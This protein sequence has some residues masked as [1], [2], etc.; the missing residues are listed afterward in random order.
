VTPFSEKPHKTTGEVTRM[1]DNNQREIQFAL[2][3]EF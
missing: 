2:R 1:L 3:L